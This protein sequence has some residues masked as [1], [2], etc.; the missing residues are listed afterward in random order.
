MSDQEK[1][2][3]S[4]SLFDSPSAESPPRAA[5]PSPSASA[6][7]T[8]RCS[9]S[10]SLSR[11]ETTAGLSSSVYASSDPSLDS[12]SSKP[13]LPPSSASFAPL[14]ASSGQQSG[15]SVFSL[16]GSSPFGRLP[17]ASFVF[18][19]SPSSDNTRSEMSSSVKI[20]YIVSPLDRRNPSAGC[21]HAQ[22]PA[23]NDFSS[24]FGACPP[25]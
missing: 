4:P 20:P 17:S 15:Q 9:E 13:N 3:H 23:P 10:V 24:S 6:T 1:H 7:G 22:A 12:T 21:A 8:A 18:S 11:S 5:Q 2:T 19:A 16:S 25:S 14:S